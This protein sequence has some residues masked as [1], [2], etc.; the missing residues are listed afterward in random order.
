MKTLLRIDSSP[1]TNTSITRQLADI[2]QEKLEKES[3]K[4]VQKRDLYYDELITLGNEDRINGY[5]TPPD[6]Q[7]DVQKSAISSSNTLATEFAES[8]EYLFAVPM[9]NFNVSAAL[10]TYIDLISRAGITFK[11]GE[12][13]PIGLLKNKKA[14]VII[15]TGGTPLNSDY[16]FVTPYLRVFLNFLGI[17]DIE[18]IK[19]ASTNT[20]LEQSLIDAKAAINDLKIS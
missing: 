9:Y 8:D 7:T 13:F 2:L 12:G 20:N 6:Q 17:T 18:F 11:Y 10:K 14:Y 15:A 3:S 4:I 1:R 5:F 19:V 16:D